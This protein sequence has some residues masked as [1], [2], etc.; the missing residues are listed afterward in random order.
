MF[1][2]MVGEGQTGVGGA[3]DEDCFGGWGRGKLGHI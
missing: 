1:E 3:E 2:K